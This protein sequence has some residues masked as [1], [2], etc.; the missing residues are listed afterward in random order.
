MKQGSIL[1]LKIDNIG[2][3]G[4]GIAMHGHTAVYVNNALPDETIKAIVTDTAKTYAHA[5]LKDIVE[6]SKYR[7]SPRCPHVRQCG[8]CQIQEM[9]YNQQLIF[10]RAKVVSNI[11]K[12]GFFQ[13]ANILN[14]IG[15]YPFFG[16]RNKAI[17]PV[18]QNSKGEIVAGFYARRSHLI[19]PSQKCHIEFDESSKITKEI[20]AHI[21]RYNIQPYN[22]SEGNGIVR[23]IMIRKAFATNEIMVSIVVNGNTI[24]HHKE[25]VDNLVS[26]TKN[27]KSV[28]L[29]VN[30]DNTNRIRGNEVISLYGNS[31]ITDEID[32]I[33]FRISPLSFYQV[34]AIQTAILY[35]KALEF[36]Q[37]TGN[38]TVFDLYCGVGTISLF[39]ARK[40]RKVYGVEVIPQAI[41]DARIN[42]EINNINNIEFIVGKAEE[43][44][45]LLVEN[46]GVK[47]DI[48]VVDPPRKGCDKA[49]LSTIIKM[50][51]QRIV[52]VSC[53][54]TSLARDLR[55]LCDNGFSL[56]IVQPVDM[57]PHSVHVECVAMLEA[58]R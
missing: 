3:D 50:L 17:Y 56:K 4:D 25:L 45:P 13:N 28:S 35:G 48:V 46:N 27:I 26:T 54:S 43:T 42:A 20:I 32:G 22:E 14:T 18:A 41:D 52:Y 58:V 53:D 49:L 36:A 31:Y 8:G 51:P 5:T 21:K 2:S 55:Y 38:E 6:K 33:K 40:A 57:F 23:Y 9:D 44:I 29:I 24:L 34:N 16:F 12:I 10:K 19:V 11:E 47:A 37:L 15:C 7:V 39:L 1:T 30:R